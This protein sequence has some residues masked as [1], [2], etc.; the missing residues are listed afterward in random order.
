M[1]APCAYV[2]YGMHPLSSFPPSPTPPSRERPPPT[3]PS[4]TY[5]QGPLPPSLPYPTHA[6]SAA[7]AAI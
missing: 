2:W 6:A 5:T 1:P 3:P 7:A 4:K